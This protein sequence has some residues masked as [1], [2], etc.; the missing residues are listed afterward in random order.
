MGYSMEFSGELK[1]TKEPKVSMIAALKSMF[2][3]DCRDHPEWEPDKYSQHLYYI[4]LELTDDL[5]GVRFNG[6]EKTSLGPAMINMVTDVM[7]FRFPGFQLS[8][9]LLAQ[10]EDIDDRW[11]LVVDGDGKASMV[12]W[13]K[14]GQKITCPHC[15]EV[16]MLEE[17]KGE[18]D[19]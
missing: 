7:R 11:R 18:T 19:G 15:E 17:A 2:N 12:D 14:I 1:F 8:G 4:D 13:P 10:G 5:L 16:F 9:E 3:K 6:A